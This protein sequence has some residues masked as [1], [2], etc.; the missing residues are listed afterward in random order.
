V[1]EKVVPPA[2]FESWTETKSDLE[3]KRYEKEKIE[4]SKAIGDRKNRIKE[5]M[6]DLESRVGQAR[7]LATVSS[8][9]NDLDFEDA[10]ESISRDSSRPVAAEAPI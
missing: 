5:R 7:L 6:E 2:R 1:F 8:P 10:E 4:D 3:D 9:G